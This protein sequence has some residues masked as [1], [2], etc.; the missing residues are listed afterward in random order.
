MIVILLFGLFALAVS[1]V[2]AF[3][4]SGYRRAYVAGTLSDIERYGFSESPKDAAQRRRSA[5][6]LLRIDLVVDKIGDRAARFGWLRDDEVRT[7]LRA[8]GSYKLTPRKVLGY[9]VLAA[10]ALPALWMWM[11]AGS[12][13]LTL[14]GAVF[15]GILGWHGPLIVL[16]RRAR[17]RLEEIDYQMPELIDLL[18]TTVEAGLGLS[19]SLQ[20]AA[21]RLQGPLGE[22]LRL[23]LAEQNMGLSTEDALANM[24]ER[25]QTPA[26]RSLVR[27]LLQGT[28][29]GVSVGKIMRDLADETRKRRR[30][31]AEERAQKA[32]T[33]ILFPLVF[34]IFPAMFVVLLGPAVVQ[35][36]HVFGGS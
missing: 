24:L 18:V 36:L 4:A 16:R 22:E 6:V 7:L 3:R 25:A 34:F 5:A 14:A 30:H 33:K 12:A 32:P 28:T 1:V 23:T 31:K 27:S 10:L 29:L 21:S 11:G 17:K 26:V 19:A 2:L 35:F 15:A 13:L 9:R 8:A 20:M